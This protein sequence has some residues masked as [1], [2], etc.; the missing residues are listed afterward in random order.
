ME[1]VGVAPVP[2]VPRPQSSRSLSVEW[3]TIKISFFL[4]V[5]F[6]CSCCR[7]A[8]SRRL[9]SLGTRIGLL[10]AKVR[11]GDDLVCESLDLKVSAGPCKLTRSMC[12]GAA[13]CPLPHHFWQRLQKISQEACGGAPQRRSSSQVLSIWRGQPGISAILSSRCLWKV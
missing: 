3:L 2:Q 9:L 5:A 8:S 13:L 7:R 6:S 11:E 12:L 10:G 1:L 4:P